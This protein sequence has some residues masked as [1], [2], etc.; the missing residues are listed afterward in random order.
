MVAAG[1]GPQSLDAKSLTSSAL[2]N[3]IAILLSPHTIQAAETIAS[4][5]RHEN[6]VKEAVESFH[7]NL[8]VQ[9]MTC[10]L[11]PRKP[12]AWVGRRVRKE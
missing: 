1:A 10:E 12:A 5:M 3:A 11:I 9:E 8:P 2:A 6:G 4:R 7:R